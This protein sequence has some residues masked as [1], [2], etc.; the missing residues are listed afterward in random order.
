[1]STSGPPG[2]NAVAYPSLP[3]DS[4]GQNSNGGAQQTSRAPAPD[5]NPA[6]NITSNGNPQETDGR[7]SNS[8]M[9]QTRSQGPAAAI[10][11][12]SLVTEDVT[13]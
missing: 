11:L 12:G 9:R 10:S 4:G 13:A 7:T 5:P 6:T 1:M 8:R 2:N 3:Q